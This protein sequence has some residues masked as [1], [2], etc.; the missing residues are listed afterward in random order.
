MYHYRI[1]TGPK[2][3]VLT[4]KKLRQITMTSAE[5]RVPRFRQIPERELKEGRLLPGSYQD[6]FYIIRIVSPIEE[7]EREKQKR[8]AAEKAAELGARRQ[9]IVRFRLSPAA[10]VFSY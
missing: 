6:L 1:W 9:N 10:G 3:E 7:E 5:G 4:E 2:L 8:A